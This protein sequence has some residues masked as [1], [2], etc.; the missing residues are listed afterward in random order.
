MSAGWFFVL[1]RPQKE[2]IEKTS[3][4][5]KKYK[6]TAAELPENLIRKQKAAD[7]LAYMLDQIAFLQNRYR[8]FDY[9]DLNN[10][11]AE[12]AKAERNRTWLRL[13]KEY[14]RSFGDTLKQQLITAANVSPRVTITT[15]VQVEKP[16]AIPE[17]VKVPANGLIKPSP[18][19]KV[20]VKGSFPQI[21]AFFERI[22]EVAAPNRR[23]ILLLVGSDLSLSGT[24]PDIQAS[25]SVTP[26][27]IGK[28]PSVD[29]KGAQP[30]APPAPAPGTP[31]APGPGAPGPGA[32]GDGGGEE[33]AA[34]GGGLRNRGG[35]AE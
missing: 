20:T 17:E 18:V 5:L 35:G 31:G 22:N 1:V 28:G 25:F 6:A 26:Y 16:P 30:A 23:T 9:G 7:R 2:E 32:P 29:F 3:A 15:A 8:S 21:L 34:D 11:D 10:A 12:K 27:M 4:N 14:N 13:M 24:S 33:P 19:L